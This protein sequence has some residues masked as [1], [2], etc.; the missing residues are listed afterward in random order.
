MNRTTNE[1]RRTTNAFLRA[2]AGLTLTATLILGQP[3]AL[4]PGDDKSVAVSKVE[5]KRKAPVSSDILRV[6]LPKPVELTLG[7]G[8]SIMVLEDHKLPNVSLQLVI[9]GAGGLYDP[10]ETPGLAGATAIM[11]K[12]GTTTRTSKQIAEQFDQ[13]GASMNANTSFG[14]K[15]T[16]VNISGLKDNMAQWMAL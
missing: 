15:S 13:L 3:P 4:K 12:E 11:L 5:R 14:S 10:A 2:T 8:M 16:T 9:D 7:N 1:Q 6:K